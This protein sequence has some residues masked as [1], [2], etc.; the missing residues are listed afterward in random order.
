MAAGWD[1]GEGAAIKKQFAA[2]IELDDAVAEQ[3]PALPGLI[4]H[5]PCCEVVRYGP[6]RAPRLMLAHAFLRCRATRGMPPR[7]Y[8]RHAAQ[9][10]ELRHPR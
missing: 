9:A 10:V 8:A 5:N 4:R 3:A 1:R 7:T 2:V 6:F